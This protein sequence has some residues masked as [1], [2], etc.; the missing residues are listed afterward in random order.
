LQ[1]GIQTRF[2]L[3]PLPDRLSRLPWWALV[4]ALIGVLF[5]WTLLTDETYFGILSRVTNGL[6][7]TLRVTFI[8][9][10]FALL[11]GLIVAL[12]RVSTNPV[13]YQ[14]STFYVEIIRGVPT[15]VLVLYVAFVA[16]PLA[17]EGIN[18]LGAQMLNANVLS[19][20]GRALTTLKT[21]NVENEFRAVVALVIAYSAFLAEVFRAGIESVER[22]QME[23]AL[24]LGM[25][26][27]QAMR[28]IV[29][30][31]AIRHV[32]PPLGNDFISML[33]DSSL[34]SVIGVT[35]LT[36]WGK[37]DQ[38]RTF[39]TLETYNVVAFLYLVMTLLLSMGVKWIERAMS[40]ERQKD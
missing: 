1:E 22:G 14:L 35:D 26:Y 15:L 31:Q 10:L 38:A 29:L 3:N 4:A 9:Y 18:A 30:R 21:G 17:V 37:L 33:K 13:I 2:R 34:V 12:G 28:Y 11:V 20:I 24:A 23:A 27:W 16:I 5:T 8:A 25:T 6:Y 32:L 40:R 39:K 19:E 7:I 36:Q